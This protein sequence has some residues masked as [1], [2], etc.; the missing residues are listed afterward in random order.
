[1]PSTAASVRVPPRDHRCTPRGVGQDRSATAYS[2]SQFVATVWRSVRF[3]VA[4]RRPYPAAALVAQRLGGR[5][6]RQTVEA[7]Q[8]LLVR[9]GG[10]P[11][12]HAVEW[13]FLAEVGQALRADHPT[14]VAALTPAEAID[15]NP[16]Y[17]GATTDR[18]LLEQLA[19]VLRAKRYALRTE[20]TYVDWC[21]RFVVYTEGLRTIRQGITEGRQGRR[22]AL[23]DP[24]GGG[25]AG[26]GEHAESGAE[27]AGVP[28]SACAGASAG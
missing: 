13:D 8:F 15:N 27:R 1:M 20:Q 6:Y 17:S 11:V 18:P 28:V 2:A 7:V 22:P 5:W 3:T 10:C 26:S 9:L 4:P 25:T 23:P 21:Y 24:F 14:R 12:A 19:R 16:R